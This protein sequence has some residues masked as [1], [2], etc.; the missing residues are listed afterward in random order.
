MSLDNFRTGEP[1]RCLTGEGRGE[2]TGQLPAFPHRSGGVG[3]DGTS[4]SSAKVSWEV[5]GG[6]CK[7]QP[8]AQAGSASEAGVVVGEVGVPRSSGDLLKTEQGAKGGHLLNA[9]RQSEGNGDGRGNPDI[10]P[11]QSPGASNRALSGSRNKGGPLN[12]PGEPNMGKPSVRF[13]EG[14][15][16]VGHWP[17]ASQSDLP[18]YS[19]DC[20]GLM[21][22]DPSWQ[23]AKLR[24]G[25]RLVALACGHEN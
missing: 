4:A 24:T 5:S 15:E 8:S 19:A 11:E 9:K 13:D 7:T 16:R 20:R 2:E 14:R 21:K 12:E 3:V 18:A 6:G 25:H 17:C 1:S 22:V 23:L 10:N